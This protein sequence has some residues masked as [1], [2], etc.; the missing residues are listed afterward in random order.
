MSEQKDGSVLVMILPI[1]LVLLFVVY[2]SVTRD[3]G[4]PAKPEARPVELSEML[5]AY[6]ANEVAA[7]SSYKG[8]RVQFRGRVTGIGQ[9]GSDAYLML[10]PLVG[11]Y[12]VEA[13]ALFDHNREAVAAASQGSVLTV[14]CTVSSLFVNLILRDCE[15]VGF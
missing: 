14:K 6:S 5:R 7:D 2:W 15:Q 11:G 10:E 8:T 9:S 3:I 13:Q 4:E 1:A 12:R